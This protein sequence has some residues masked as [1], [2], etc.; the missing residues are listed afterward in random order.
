[1]VTALLFVE[2]DPLR[3]GPRRTGSVDVATSLLLALGV[4]IGVAAGLLGAGPSLLTVL[5]LTTAG[6]LELR[7]AITTALVVVAGMSLVAFIP[8]AKAHEV[9]WRAAVVFGVAS[10]AGA[11]VGGR[12]S[13][14]I[15]ARV[16]LVVFLLAMLVAAGAMVWERSPRP[17][18]DL[19]TPKPYAARMAAGGLLLGAL[20]GMVGLGGGFAIVPLLVL[21][22]RTPMRSAIG[23]SILI[24]AMNTL[25][26][27]AGHLPH[28]AVDWRIAATLG[29]AESLGGLAGVRLGNRLSVK[30]LRYA[31]ASFMLAAAVF[32]GSTMLR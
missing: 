30:V 6:G 20:T 12:V 32:L 1:M 9:V 7:S 25:A 14:L 18:A 3:A 22:A 8:Y 5:L 28:L 21:F 15:P 31:F 23:T 2:L 10:M 16:L 26:G 17:N 19:G 29:I 13:S 24:I 11:V 27:L 4:C